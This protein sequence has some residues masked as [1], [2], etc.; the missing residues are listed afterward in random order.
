MIQLISPR[1]QALLR[2]RAL[3]L[4][5]FTVGYNLL[6]GIFSI[7]LG[8]V[9][10]SVA[11]ISFGLDSGIE[12]LAALVL[13]WRLTRKEN[14]AA[15]ARQLE[16]R[17][18]LLVGISFLVLALYI[19]WEATSKIIGEAE[20]QTSWGGI[21]LAVSSLI[22]M[23]LLAARKKKVAASLKSWSLASEAT[24]T[25]LCAYLSAVLLGGLLLNALLGWWWADP[26]A[27]LVIVALM[28]KEGWDNIQVGLGRKEGSCCS[29]C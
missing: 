18:V 28:V 13:L 24:Q 21:L 5:I 19:I 25:S 15:H 20:P 7:L 12:V 17:A 23:P 10:A 22:V 4:E 3:R 1:T 16:R 9:A 2:K 11:L 14:D 26:L 6:E 27:S 29:Q 8:V